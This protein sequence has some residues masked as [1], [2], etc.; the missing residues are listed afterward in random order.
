MIGYIA[1]ILITIA[2]LP[3]V[4]DT[5]KTKRCTLTWTTLTILLT[6]KILWSIYAIQTRDWPL[7][8]SNTFNVLQLVLMLHYKIK[9]K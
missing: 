1:A 7:L 2:F 9:N 5:F 3:Q 4:Y 8:G 6:A